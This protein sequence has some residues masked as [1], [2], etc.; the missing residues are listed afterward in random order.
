M[1][2]S[3]P[4]GTLSPHAILFF[5]KIIYICFQYCVGIPKGFVVSILQIDLK[6]F[7]YKLFETQYLIVS[8]SVRLNIH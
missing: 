2:T 6:L 4:C 3:V 8:N 5:C 1:N 7:Y